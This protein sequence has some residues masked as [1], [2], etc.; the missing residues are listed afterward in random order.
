MDGTQEYDLEANISD[1]SWIAKQGVSIKIVSGSTTRYLEGDDLEQT[2]VERLNREIPGWRAVSA[3]T[4]EFQYVRQTGG[5]VFLG[6]QPAPDITGTDTWTAIV[7]VV[8]IPS[9]LSLDADEPF[10]Y[11]SNVLKRMRP[12]HRALVHF[13]AYDLEKFR[14]D[15]V[16]AATQ[17]KLFEREV[18][19]Y[20]ARQAPK[21]GQRI[22]LARN[23][24]GD[25]M[26]GS[27]R[28]YDPR[29][30]P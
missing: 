26:R 5:Q 23:Y 28:R 6:F 19:D 29:V 20:L 21:G 11:S 8:I 3:G 9:D 7:P 10:T 24:R 27:P 18:D 16:R 30:W 13:G 17:L 22:R 2:S 15:T 1:Y 4:P 14:K 12:W 25:A